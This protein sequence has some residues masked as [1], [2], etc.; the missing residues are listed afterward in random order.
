MS[1][2]SHAYANL[3]LPSH[4]IF[5]GDTIPGGDVKVRKLTADEEAIL[6]T[7]GIDVME[8]ISRI[9][10]ACSQLPGGA[11]HGQ[12]LVTDRLAIL[13]FQRVIAFGP[14]YQFQWRCK[15]CR[16][17]VKGQVDIVKDLPEITPDTLS[18]KWQEQSWGDYV[19]EE[20]FTVHLPD[21]DVDVTLRFLRGDQE[22]QVTRRAK[23]LRMQN[24]NLS[25]PTDN[26]RKAL[27]IVAIGDKEPTL[28]ERE[29]WVKGITITDK[30]A[31]RIGN[32][33]R[34]TGID[35]NTILDCAQCG[36]S[37]GIT[38]PFDEEFFQ[39]SYL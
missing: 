6:Q 20:P 3:K 13:L 25:D 18:Y 7:Q 15:H 2:R 4:G 32:D 30:A 23:Q 16:A 31:L 11:K 22:E 28:L 5:Y 19:P 34:E 37:N 27:Q 29:M 21:A 35:L 17:V 10:T 14:T 26:L 12:L 9:I 38:L 1:E 36:A 8:R 39:P 33:R 24:A